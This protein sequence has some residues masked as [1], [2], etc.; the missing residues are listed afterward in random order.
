[1]KKA[2][3]GNQLK[4]V[5]KEI[6][7]LHGGMLELHQLLVTADHHNPY[8]DCSCSTA[9]LLRKLEDCAFEIEQKLKLEAARKQNGG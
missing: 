5:R 8:K 6:L 1:M 3:S 7:D 9:T 4:K 2:G